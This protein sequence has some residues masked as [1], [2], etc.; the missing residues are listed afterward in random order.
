VPRLDDQTF[1]PELT[2]SARY[3]LRFRYL[4]RGD[5]GSFEEPVDLF[6]RVAWNLAEAERAFCPD[7][8]ETAIAEWAERFFS[9]MADFRFLPNA[10]TLLGAGRP[11]QQLFACFVLPVEDSVG[12]IFE[13]LRMAALVHSRGGGTGFSFS[14]L[15][16]RGAPI[17]TGG[18]ATGPVSFMRVFDAAT[19]TI[20]AGGTGWGANMGVLA[21][22]HP[23]VR[24]FIGA[25]RDRGALRNFN[26][27][28]GVTDAF[29][30]AC[31]AGR[32]WPLVDP[33]TG[34]VA[35]SVPARELLALLAEAAWATGD[36]GVVFL[37]RI[38]AGNPTPELGRIESTNPC[39]EAPLLPFEAC[40]LGGLN[41]A[42]FADEGTGVQWAALREA[43]ALAL[44]MMD[45]VIEASRFPLPEIRA[46]T[47][48]TRKIGIG[49]MGFADLLIRLGVPYD[50]EA[51]VEL[52]GDLMRAVQEGTRAASEG[53]AAE[54]GAFPAFPGSRWARCGDPP[55]RNAT[56]TSNAPNSTIGV[57]AG[58]S[59][60]IE[61]LFAVGLERRLA[62]GDRL[63]EL[64]PLFVE[65]AKARG[66]ASEALF[67]R[68]RAAGALGDLPEIPAD[69][70]RVFVTA[71][72]VAPRW[73]VRV[74]AAFQA[75]TELGVSKT[76]NLPHDATP[77]D[78]ADVFLLAHDLGCKGI[79]CY[80]DRCQETQFLVAGRDA[81][82]GSE[83]SCPTCA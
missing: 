22:D 63:A 78:V 40:C 54:R 74:Q 11:L 2:E 1:Q 13:T 15:R 70:R 37:D 67:A 23:D 72:E 10:P 32:D 5:D 50:S 56:T 58:C 7:L 66:L 82:A 65:M 71:R 33:S 61:P 41:V 43:A 9:V 26:I 30:E 59:P 44:R 4:A 17:A 34:R 8:A 46:A 80:R 42:R 83:A 51:A 14:R 47:R 27:S 28:V 12:G 57:I 39:G 48:R 29:I 62:N 35:E 76:I 21:C 68:V 36:P 79:T 24:E 19:E 55:R 64:H 69:L 60:G 52:A 81:G 20:K 38:E 31:R 53:L 73:H 25:K 75:H 3:L 16:P 77:Q 6:R 45:N 18:H 49:V